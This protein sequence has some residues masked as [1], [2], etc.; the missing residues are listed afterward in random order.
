MATFRQK[1]L[2]LFYPLVLK[3][4]KKGEKGTVKENLKNS[5]PQESFYKLGVTLNNGKTLNFSDLAGKKVLVVNTASNCGYT[6]QYAELQM[7]HEKMGDKLNIIG[8]PANDFGAQEQGDDHEIA[9]FCQVNYGVTFP[10]AKKAVVIKDES[11]QPVYKWLT[12]AAKNGWNDHAPDWNFS[13]YVIDENGNLIHYFGSA[14]SPW[15]DEF[16][17][18]LEA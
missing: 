8:F 13:K 16:L 17:K 9:Q 15:D 2:R 6:G 3:N 14:V 18:V 10:I 11:Q 5:A 1:L 4:G 7:L 12:N